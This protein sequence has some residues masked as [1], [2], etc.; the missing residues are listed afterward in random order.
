M[1]NYL[2]VLIAIFIVAS[3]N[4]RHDQALKS[5]D[6]NFILNVANEHFANK[7]WPKAIALYERLSNLVAGTD[8]APNV[9]FNSAYANY[10]DENYK[11]AGHQFKNFAV[12]FPQDPRREEASYMS[13]LCYY[14]GSMDY[15][16]DQSSTELA[17]NELQ[18]FLN[19]YPNSERG[20]N[21]NKL[22]EELSYKLEYKAFENGKQYYKMGEYRAANTAL[23]NVLEDFPATKLRPAIYDLILKSRYEL[24]MNSIYDLKQERI[25]SALAFTR[26]VE[27]ELPGSSQAETAADL[28]EKLLREKENFAKVQQQVENNKA[29]LLAR[30]QK[31]AEKNAAESEKTAR[32]ALRDSVKTSTPPPAITL[33]IQK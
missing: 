30:Q 17:I 6:K 16:L 18:N 5:A 21:I 11:L 24:A 19:N 15:N 4:T 26:Q 22:I 3:C 32:Q 31:E 28:R 1:K 13:A 10:Y 29:A 12:T 7:K 23:E 2:I 33:P 14:E 25:E 9:V 8:D 27:K 20:V